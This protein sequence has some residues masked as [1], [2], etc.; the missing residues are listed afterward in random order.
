M[1]ALVPSR[2]AFQVVGDTVL[3]RDDGGGAPYGTNTEL[4][5]KND[6][7]S[8]PSALDRTVYL[9]F[10]ISALSALKTMGMALTNASLSIDLI[11]EGIGTN[12]TI[13]VA[14]IAENATAEMFAESN[15]LAS[16]SDVLSG[17]TDEAVNFSKVFGGAALGGFEISRSDQGKTLKFSGPELLKAIRADTNGVLSLVLYRTEDSPSGDTFASKEHATLHPALLVVDY[18]TPPPGTLI[19]LY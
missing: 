4:I 16:T 18:W 13:Y 11:A 17:S 10:D 1:S 2:S 15:L 5:V 3:R 14:A 19:R 12:H 8:G 9:R 7:G 6:S